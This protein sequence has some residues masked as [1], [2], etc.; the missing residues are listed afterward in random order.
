MDINISV[1]VSGS[2]LSDEKKRATSSSFFLFVRAAF[3][4]SAVSVTKSQPS[5]VYVLYREGMMARAKKKIQ[6]V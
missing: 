5:P 6:Y 4:T 2:I 1:S 3:Y